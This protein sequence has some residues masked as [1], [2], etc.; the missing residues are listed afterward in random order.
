MAAC[1]CPARRTL[2][3]QPI[4][5][6]VLATSLACDHPAR[7]LVYAT[8]SHTCRLCTIV[9]L[10]AVHTITC[11]RR[12]STAELQRGLQVEAAGRTLDSSKRGGGASGRTNR[13]SFV[14]LAPGTLS[15]PS[16]ISF[17]HPSTD[18]CA[19]TPVLPSPAVYYQ[20]DSLAHWVSADRRY[21]RSRQMWH[22]DIARTPSS[23][24]R[25]RRCLLGTSGTTLS[26]CSS[27]MF[28]GCMACTRPARLNRLVRTFPAHRR[29]TR[30]CWLLPTRLGRLPCPADNC[31]TTL[32]PSC[33]HRWMASTKHKRSI[34]GAQLDSGRSP[35]PCF[36]SP[37]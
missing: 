27:S 37:V 9:I 13:P 4:Q 3:D 10:C 21:D 32:R 30:Q 20:R 36:N 18:V 7:T 16:H 35:P 34:L 29:C 25:K 5:T 23:P 24:Q 15:N 8:T 17:F 28:P 31:C 11:R 33:R 22:Q 26:R 14:G 6:I 12:A 1:C 2:Y 19:S